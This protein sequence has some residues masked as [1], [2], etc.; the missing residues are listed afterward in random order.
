MKGCRP[1]VLKSPIC[2]YEPLGMYP[3]DSTGGV[4]Q[5]AW[6]WPW[7]ADMVDMAA[8]GWICTC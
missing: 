4:L 5:Q 6:L 7:L 1:Q 2:S 8:M 3:V